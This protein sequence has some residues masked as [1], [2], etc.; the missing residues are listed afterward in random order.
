MS[1][2]ESVIQSY[3][4]QAYSDFIKIVEGSEGKGITPLNIASLCLNVMQIAGRFVSLR[5][6]EKKQV[7][8]GVFDRYISEHPD[9]SILVSILPNM[10]DLFVSVENKELKINVNP[11][12][13]FKICNRRK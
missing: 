3:I 11:S 9:A 2:R 4:N 13:C 7:V 12:N 5:G 1:D 6:L 10:I 8:L